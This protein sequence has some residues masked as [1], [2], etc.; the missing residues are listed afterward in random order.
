MII[1][2]AQVVPGELQKIGKLPAVI[3][4]INQ[5]I[6]FD[7]LYE[8]Y[9][10]RCKYIRVICHDKAEKV[11]QCLAK[12]ASEKLIIEN[13]P[14][15][16]D[17][18]Y[19]IY[20]ALRNTDTPVIINFADTIVMDGLTQIVEDICFFSWDY[21]SDK[22]TFFDEEDGTIVSVQNKVPLTSVEK[23]KLFVG[24]FAIANTRYFRECLEEAF[25]TRERSE[26]TFYYAL[27]QYSR[28]FP[29]NMVEA[30][31][32]F[33]IGHADT[34]YNSNLEV[35]AREF[36]HIFIDKNRGILKKTSENKEKFIGEIRWYL[37]LPFGY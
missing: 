36:N 21:L 19:T 28:R 32:W 3:Y 23:K 25:N 8:Q 13:L 18:G 2:S 11:R 26:S 7:Y 17:L 33:D 9:K 24:V 12:Y 27:M 22:W 30:K 4:L 5:K 35:R 1:P 20:F 16:S 10:D 34:Y 31:E 15:L 6:M 14:V 29:V 37:K